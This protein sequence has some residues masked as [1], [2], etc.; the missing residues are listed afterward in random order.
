MQFVERTTLL[1]AHGTRNRKRACRR[2]QLGWAGHR[3]VTGSPIVASHDC[4][5]S[6]DSRY[7]SCHN[8]FTCAS[9]QTSAGNAGK[10]S[11]VYIYIHIYT[12]IYT[13]IYIHIY[14]D[15]Y[16]YTYIHIYIYIYVC[17]YIYTYIHIYIYI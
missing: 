14:I 11:Y 17:I 13:Y 9:L 4:L 8:P 7:C 15:I 10:H 16:I 3:V 12:Y 1:H 6:L 2:P 5:A